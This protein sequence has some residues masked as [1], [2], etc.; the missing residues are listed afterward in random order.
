MVDDAE[1]GISMGI[2]F[3]CKTTY[4]SPFQIGVV[5]STANGVTTYVIQVSYETGQAGG[6][7][8][9]FNST[10]IDPFTG[11]ETDKGW[12]STG[13]SFTLGDKVIPY[14]KLVFPQYELIK[15]FSATDPDSGISISTII[16]NQNEKL[17]DII[18]I[19][20][21]FNTETVVELNGEYD[22]STI[23]FGRSY[24]GKSDVVVDIEALLKEKKLPLKV[25]F[26]HNVDD[27]N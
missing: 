22:G 10:G 11:D 12:S 7:M 1:N 4:D 24:N 25:I 2:Y 5:K 3:V 26:H 18:S 8:V 20:P 6:D 14:A 19:D 9:V 17:T 13:T 21:N 16:G 23:R 15:E 27:S